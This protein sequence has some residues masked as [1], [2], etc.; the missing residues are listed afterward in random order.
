MKFPYASKRRRVG[1]YQYHD[2]YIDET[3][4]QKQQQ[5]KLW[6]RFEHNHEAET[7]TI[8]GKTS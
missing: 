4:K 7:G 1:L 5:N 8:L 6:N 2:G 3:Q